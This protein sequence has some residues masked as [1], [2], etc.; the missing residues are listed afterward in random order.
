MFFFPFL[1]TL[2]AFNQVSDVR[3]R[4]VSTTVHYDSSYVVCI[5]ASGLPDALWSV[6]SLVTQRNSNLTN[7]D[8]KKSDTN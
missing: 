7:A 5:L 6:F 4:D 3:Q 8:I 1:W 2:Y